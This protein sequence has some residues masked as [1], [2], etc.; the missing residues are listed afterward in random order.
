[1]RSF[2]L[3]SRLAAVDVRGFL[4][5]QPGALSNAPGKSAFLRIAARGRA[6]R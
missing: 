3:V 4:P 6:A 5:R 1:M 2:V